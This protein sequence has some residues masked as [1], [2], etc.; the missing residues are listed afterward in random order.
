MEKVAIAKRL[1]CHKNCSVFPCIV[2]ISSPFNKKHL[3][4]HALNVSYTS[5][6]F[7]ST[8]NVDF[9]DITKLTGMCSINKT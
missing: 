4:G 3:F 7:K 1:D 9:D 8:F 2:G 6:T 5:C